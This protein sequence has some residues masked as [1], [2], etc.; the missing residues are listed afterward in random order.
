M[1]WGVLNDR[2][3]LALKELIDGKNS[4]RILAV[5]G[6]AM[7]DENLR[8]HLEHRLR[9]DKDMNDKIFKVGGP[10]GN[11]GPKIDLGYQLYML[12]RPARTT[13]YGISEIRNLF[14]HSL[15]MH[16]DSTEK[17]MTD[18]VGKLKMHEGRTHYSLPNNPDVPSEHELEPINN[19]RD[20]FY[21]N[22]KLSILY[23]MSDYLKHGQN[24]NI[25]INYGPIVP[26]PFSSE[27]P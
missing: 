12:D 14:A 17:K 10:L 27:M 26:A 6:G 8:V 4:D 21:V 24:S 22:L 25:P 7:L 18:A 15:T 13:M 20:L 19:K 3:N 2:V 16:F 5:V 11:L 1:V 9:P 23:L